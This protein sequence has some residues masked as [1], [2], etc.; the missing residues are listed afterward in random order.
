MH[1]NVE[2]PDDRGVVNVHMT[3]GQGDKE[4]VYQVLSLNVAGKPVVHLENKAE[5]G[6]L[7]AKAAKMFG[8]QWR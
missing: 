5:E 7:K 4:L 8:V 6:V 2:G 3:K 1:F